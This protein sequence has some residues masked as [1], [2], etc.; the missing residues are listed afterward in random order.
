[1]RFSRDWSSD[2]CSSDLDLAAVAFSGDYTDLINTPTIPA[3]ISGAT[4]LTGSDETSTL[5]NSRQL[6]AGSNITFDTSTPGQLEISASG[7]DRKSVRVGK[8]CRDRR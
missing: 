5:S 3:D 4:F 8:E 2:V 6:V 7:G 1:T